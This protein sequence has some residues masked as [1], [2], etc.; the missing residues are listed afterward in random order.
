MIFLIHCKIPFGRVLNCQELAE[1][2]MNHDDLG[3]ANP[4]TAEFNDMY[5]SGIK[6]HTYINYVHNCFIIPV[7]L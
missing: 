7:Y 2:M 6:V 5:I 3:R 1:I 4:I